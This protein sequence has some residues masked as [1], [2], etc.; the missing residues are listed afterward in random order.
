MELLL[1]SKDEGMIEAG[2]RCSCGCAP[3]VTIS[4]GDEATVEDV[5]CCGT[6]F[7]VG[8][9]AEDRIEAA[10]GTAVEVQEFDAPW[11]Q[12]LEAAWTAGGG[13]HGHDHG[14]HDHG[15]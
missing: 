10:D 8:V 4:Q 1:A 9:G 7:V 2:Y 5:C 14:H 3:S 6:R 13:E 15:G 12:A 11:G